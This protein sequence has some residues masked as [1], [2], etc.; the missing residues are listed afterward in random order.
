[1]PGRHQ[2]VGSGTSAQNRMGRRKRELKRSEGAWVRLSSAPA[3]S[4]WEPRRPPV[5]GDLA[6]APNPPL[7]LS[8]GLPGQDVCQRTVLSIRQSRRCKDPMRSWAGLGSR[9]RMLARQGVTGSEELPPSSLSA[10]PSAGG[11]GRSDEQA[12][13]AYFEAYLRS[14]PDPTIL[15]HPGP[16][17][18]VDCYLRDAHHRGFPLYVCDVCDVHYQHADGTVRAARATARWS[19]AG[20]LA[21]AF[22]KPKPHTV[23]STRGVDVRRIQAVLHAMLV[24]APVGSVAAR[25]PLAG[26]FWIGALLIVVDAHNPGVCCLTDRRLLPVGISR[27]VQSLSGR[28]AARMLTAAQCELEV[29]NGPATDTGK[30]DTRVQM[31]RVWAHIHARG[32]ARRPPQADTRHRRRDQPISIGPSFDASHRRARAVIYGD[33][34]PEPATSTRRQRLAPRSRPP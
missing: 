5:Q 3:L 23:R 1:M 26:M 24:I 34:Y 15:G 17:R 29:I 11:S 9:R 13:E 14:H 7:F 10:S 21:T 22:P 8:L 27:R 4:Q 20:S 12:L 2:E 33:E 6:A 30:H 31:P 16:I 28:G 18:S 19:P 32:R 25:S